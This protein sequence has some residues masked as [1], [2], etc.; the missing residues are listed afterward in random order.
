MK[1]RE[2]LR[3][4]QSAGA[5]VSDRTARARATL[6]ARRCSSACETQPARS[7]RTTR[8]GRAA[9]CMCSS[10]CSRASA[11]GRRP[12]RETG[13]CVTVCASAPANL[14]TNRKL[15]TLYTI[16][17]RSP[18]PLTW[19]CGRMDTPP[20]RALHGRLTGDT[21]PAAARCSYARLHARQAGNS[22][23][24]CMATLFSRTREAATPRIT[25]STCRS[26]SRWPAKGH[27]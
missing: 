13:D 11:L 22:R 24:G 25:K 20:M 3:N 15:N 17:P 12:T 26:R 1:I 2:S 8:A 10:A 23:I 27:L 19:V 16:T 4:R 18:L 5:G 7:R 14:K 6:P 21:R 9:R